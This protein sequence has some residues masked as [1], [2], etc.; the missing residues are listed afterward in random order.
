LNL[1]TYASK[2]KGF[3]IIKNKFENTKFKIK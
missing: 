2:E 1:I 3:K